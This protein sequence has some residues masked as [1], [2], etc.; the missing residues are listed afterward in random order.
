MKIT[1]KQFYEIARD[2]HA[3]DILECWDETAFNNYC[4]EF[5]DMTRKQA[6]FLCAFCASVSEEELKATEYYSKY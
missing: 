6:I 2:L 3:F 5:G 4:A 1:Y